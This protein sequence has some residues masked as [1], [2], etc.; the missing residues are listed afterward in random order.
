MLMINIAFFIFII[1]GF[2]G[3]CHLFINLKVKDVS[4]FALGILLFLGLSFFIF[5]V[6]QY[7]Q[8]VGNPFI[9]DAQTADIRAG[10]GAL[11]DYFGGFLNP[12]L[13]FLSFI[14][15]LYTL[16]LN[17]N[18]LKE[19]RKE[20][21]RSA[22]AQEDSKTV[23]SEQL[24]I[25]SLQQFDSF[26]FS[27]SEKLLQQISVIENTIAVPAET[28]FIDYLSSMTKEEQ[29]KFSLIINL[30]Y[31]TL[32]LIERRLRNNQHLTPEEQISLKLDYRNIIFHLIDQ[33]II[34]IM[35]LNMENIHDLEKYEKYQKIIESF[36]LLEYLILN[37]LEYHVDQSACMNKIVYF[38]CSAFGRSL[39]FERIRS[40]II[41]Q[42]FRKD[43]GEDV[44]FI[45]LIYEVFKNT[46]FSSSHK[47]AYKVVVSETE[48]L[49]KFDFNSSK[50]KT[51]HRQKDYIFKNIEIVTGGG[52]ILYFVAG[53]HY[54]KFLI[55]LV[56][57]TRSQKI[58]VDK[59][60]KL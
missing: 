53:R 52:I 55:S 16:Y 40:H 57:E 12:I 25:Q 26:F 14:A 45:H 6:V 51:I 39:H 2:L 28:P 19:T 4:K 1:F 18:E 33:N 32:S 34:I 24:K 15:L 29:A 48:Y 42:Y 7:V 22:K 59:I 8:L 20:L 60:I 37:D 44:S 47:S 56:A 9:F 3:I 46:G 23:M 35:L 50:L 17:Q 27:L 13:A 38:D 54:M 41:F 5:L 31:E 43:M 58:I 11:G 21:S 10:L 30:V 49:F 36:S